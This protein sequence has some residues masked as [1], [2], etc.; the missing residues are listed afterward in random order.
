MNKQDYL[1]I[2][3]HIAYRTLVGSTARAASI[4]RLA[5]MVGKVPALVAAAVLKADKKIS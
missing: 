4:N 3:E 1:G 5:Y 2:V